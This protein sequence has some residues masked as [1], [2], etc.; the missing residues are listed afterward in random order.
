M[1]M[2]DLRSLIEILEAN[3]ELTRVK[4]PTDIKKA[5]ASMSESDK[6]DGQALLFENIVG[7]NVPLVSGLLNNTKRIAFVSYLP[8]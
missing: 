7:F 6:K 8:E 5:I 2:D 3:G 1:P 4:E